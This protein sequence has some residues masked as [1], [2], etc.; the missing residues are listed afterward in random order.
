MRN[1]NKI[2]ILILIIYTYFSFVFF[3]KNYKTKS[4]SKIFENGNNIIISK[5]YNIK[6]KSNSILT[7]KFHLKKSIFKGINY[8]IDQNEKIKQNTKCDYHPPSIIENN[9]KRII[10][11]GDIHGDLYA[12]LHAL[13]KAKV[14]D[15]LGNWIGNETIVIQLGDQIDKGGRGSLDPTNDE[16]EELK[17]IE[18]MHNL[19]FEAKKKN[20]AVY[21]LIGNHEI[22]NVMADFRYV[23]STHLNGFKGTDTRKKLFKPGGAIARKL[24]CN[25]N[26]IMMIGNWI[27]VHAGILPQHIEKYTIEQ[28]N[29]S[30]RDILLGNI[31]INN[32]DN[33]LENIIFGND[34]ILW[35][36]YYIN[37][38]DR[39][40]KLNKTLEILNINEKGGMVIGHTVQNNI[41]SVCNNKL[42]MADVGMSSAFGKKND[43]N[44]R[45][46]I[47]EIINDGKIVRP[48]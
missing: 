34:G 9:N 23:T 20:G 2:L 17:V 33:Q 45:V 26:G 22:M 21:N 37:N 32:V 15:K 13:Y 46:E 40:Y 14:I 6:K 19:H 38:S 18:F 43:D 7:M 36:R 35:N 3:D 41:N 29:S 39:C 24:A 16:I 25:T 44:D 10:V 12:L 47:L 4:I 11:I 42:W 27:F 31:S 1:Y 30:I 28:I 5:H 8:Y 48:I